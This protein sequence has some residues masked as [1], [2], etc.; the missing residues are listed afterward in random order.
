MPRARSNRQRRV[1]RR[2]LARNRDQGEGGRAGDALVHVVRRARTCSTMAFL[3]VA[4][5]QNISMSS[6]ITTDVTVSPRLCTSLAAPA[7][8][9][10]DSTSR[11]CEKLILDA[12]DRDDRDTLPNICIR[13]LPRPLGPMLVLSF[14]RFPC[15]DRLLSLNERPEVSGC[16][17]LMS[18]SGA[19]D[20][21]LPAT[22]S[23]LAAFWPRLE[24]RSMGPR[25]RAGPR[26]GPFWYKRANPCHKTCCIVRFHQIPPIMQLS[27]KL[28]YHHRILAGPKRTP[29]EKGL[30]SPEAIY[31][32]R[33]RYKDISG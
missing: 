10:M 6:D 33:W 19:T 27:Y 31:K 32:R 5:A 14:A 21:S 25:A 24:V 7:V 9:S 18:E 4:H 13:A 22:A 12:L 29:L 15:A 11:R 16:H 23:A 20:S 2:R 1:S 3:F 28:R 17:G 8:S 30:A 26:A